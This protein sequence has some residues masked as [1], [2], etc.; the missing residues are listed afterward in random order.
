M[1]GRAVLHVGQRVFKLAGTWSSG[2]PEPAKVQFTYGG[3]G[4]LFNA[5]IIPT[6]GG[7]AIVDRLKASEFEITV[8]A[9]SPPGC[10]AT[11][12]HVA[13]IVKGSWSAGR[14]GRGGSA[15]VLVQD[16]CGSAAA[17]ARVTGTF[18]GGFDETAAGVTDGSGTATVDTVATAKGTVSYTFC[19][20]DVTGA[21]PYDPGAN[22]ETCE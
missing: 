13:S 22:A 9:G 21:L 14:G 17:G 5:V 10:S 18:S 8:T 12:L 2:V 1:A 11:R 6:E 7:A 4:N 19:V 20:A 3:A 15:Q 16:D